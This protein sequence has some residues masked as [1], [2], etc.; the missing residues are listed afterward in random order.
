MI[1]RRDEF[2]A[3]LGGAAIVGS[4]VAATQQKLATIG[5]L[6][7]TTPSA[8]APWTSALVQRLR[9]L[10]WIEGRTI[11]IQYRWAE[12]NTNRYSEI[13]AEF[14]QRKVD[15]IVT[16][17]G[18]VSSVKKLTSTIPIV[19]A[20]STDPVRSGLVESLARPGGNITGLSSQAIEASSKRL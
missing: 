15:V 3:G 4:R 6:G 5:L 12:A 17:G 10:G 18:A 14:V 16:S 9:E 2:I 7:T 8:W 13:A 1:R 11:D 20:L 19:F